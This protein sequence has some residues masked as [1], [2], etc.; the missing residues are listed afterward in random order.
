[1]DDESRLRI[2]RS[3]T[4]TLTA[5]VLLLIIGFAISMCAA[6][7]TFWSSATLEELQR[8]HRGLA[9]DVAAA[10]Q[11]YFSEP[12][13]LSASVGD[14]NHAIYSF[15]QAHPNVSVFI[16]DPNGRILWSPGERDATAK[17]SIDVE[18]IRKFLAGGALPLYGTNPGGKRPTVFAAAPLSLF[19]RPGYVYLTLANHRSSAWSE[20]FLINTSLRMLMVVAI[21]CAIICG[22]IGA[23]A[24]HL[25]TKR[26]RDIAEVLRRYRGGDFSKRLDDE[27]HDELAEVS[28]A[29]NSMLDTVE[30]QLDLLRRKDLVRR[31]LISNI[32]HDLKAPVTSISGHLDLL[33]DR[34]AELPPER[35]RELVAILRRSTGMLSSMLADL[36]ELGRLEAK[37]IQP[38]RAR[39]EI[40]ELAEEVVAMLRAGADEAGVALN[41]NSDEDLHGWCDP[42]LVLRVFMNLVDNAIRHTPSGGSVSVRV[43]NAPGGVL[44]SVSDTGVGIPRESLPFLFERYFQ[45][46]GDSRRNGNAGLGLAIVKRILEAHDVSISV[47]STENVG[48]TFSFVIPSPSPSTLSEPPPPSRAGA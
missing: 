3:F 35:R 18:P 1:M 39:C 4:A 40:G 47:E 13:A 38:S 45:I 27:G 44:V 34:D 21:L 46:D 41:V 37:D 30:T 7:Y 32:W 28:H 24:I 22:T 25:V 10:L 5:I 48:T 2:H 33:I 17:L 9:A 31:E 11:G 8:T 20:F 23:L 14:V 12:G 26:F 36:Y 43:T 42:D 6:F 16:L 29:V 15:Q 19:G